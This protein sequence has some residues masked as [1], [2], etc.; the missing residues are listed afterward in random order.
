MGR[1][2]SGP[3]EYNS[4][5]GLLPFM[6]DSSIVVDLGNGRLAVV[7]PELRMGR[8]IPIFLIGGMIASATD[9]L[10]GFYVDRLQEV[11]VARERNP[12][13]SD[14][15][16]VLRVVEAAPA[17]GD[18]ITH[19]TIAGPPNPRMW[20]PWDGW[21]VGRDGRVFAVRNRDE[22]RV[23]WFFRDGRS[24][25]GPVIESERVAVTGEDR[26]IW[27][28]QHPR[29]SAGGSVAFGNR[30]PGP[31]AAAAFPSRFPFANSRDVWVDREGRG[32]VGRYE[33]QTE[34]RPLYDVFDAAGRRT[35]R[36]R[37]PAGR[38]LVGFGRGALYAVRVDD[39][40][41]QWLERYDISARP[42][43]REGPRERRR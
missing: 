43:N 3:G 19:V 33:H 24:V 20:Y 39:V 23:D 7:G 16:A 34:K 21:A 38:Q 40:D 11:R 18:T 9:T 25:S 4:P 27:S 22:Y 10:G 35:A 12:A 37:L 36:V 14:R 1:E 29:G 32:W 13:A 15:A 2:G 26:R 28:E 30:P 8:T 42:V 17:S 31:P 41:L 6:G 5:I